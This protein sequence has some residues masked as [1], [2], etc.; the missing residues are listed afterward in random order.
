[1]NLVKFFGANVW[2]TH[3]ILAYSDIQVMT[4]TNLNLETV[5]SSLVPNPIP[6]FSVM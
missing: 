4:F 1:M 2:H 5:F 6:S 3:S